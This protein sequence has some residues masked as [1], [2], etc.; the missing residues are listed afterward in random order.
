MSVN[1]RECAGINHHLTNKK[2]T[3]ND[4]WKE[5]Q[6]RDVAVDLDLGNK[7]ATCIL[8]EL[9]QCRKLDQVN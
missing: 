6:I 9:I 3:L 4:S 5:P 1:M 8:K 2:N 7:L